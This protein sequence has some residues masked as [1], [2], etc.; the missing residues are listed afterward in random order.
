[1]REVYRLH[2]EDELYSFLLENSVRL[3]LAIQYIGKE[4]QKFP[5][6]QRAILRVFNRLKDEIAKMDLG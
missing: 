1:M 5:V 2:K 3:D 4:Q 6:L